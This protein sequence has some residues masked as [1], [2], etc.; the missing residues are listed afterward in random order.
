MMENMKMMM[1]ISLI[2]KQVQTI[3][4]ECPCCGTINRVI[5]SK[6][7]GRPG[8]VQVCGNCGEELH[9]DDNN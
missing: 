9:G 5:E 2:P 4:K 3:D 1:I 8:I 6:L 7:P